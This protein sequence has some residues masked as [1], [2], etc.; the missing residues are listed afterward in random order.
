ME[1]GEPSSFRTAENKCD[2]CK[3]RGVSWICTGCKRVLCVDKDRSKEILERLQ[4][5]DE[6]PIIC[7]RFPVLSNLSRGNVPAF[8]TDMGMINGKQV[9]GGMSCFQIAHPKYF[10]RPCDTN[11]ENEEG[12]NNQLLSVVT[13]SKAT[14]ASSPVAKTT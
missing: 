2:L 10:C 9:F 1:K 14:T 3:S 12:M 7:R 5:A 13:S 8:Y 4:D 6:G 11:D